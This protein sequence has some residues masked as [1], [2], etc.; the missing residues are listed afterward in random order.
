VPYDPEFDDVEKKVG[1]KP[2]FFSWKLRFPLYFYIGS[3]YL[4]FLSFIAYD[5]TKTGGMTIIHL[6]PIYCVT[7]M[8]LILYL[9]YYI[10]EKG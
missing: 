1:R 8:Y 10:A 3:F 9:I 4:G 2:T 6:M 5:V 7:V